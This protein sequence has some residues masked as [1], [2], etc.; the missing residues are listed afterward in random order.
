MEIRKTPGICTTRIVA[1][2]RSEHLANPRPTGVVFDDTQHVCTVALIAG[3]LIR[4]LIA[5]PN[6]VDLSPG[7]R[8]EQRH[9]KRH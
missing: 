2:P 9:Q 8:T 3:D 4:W 1:E 5:E 6:M 7:G